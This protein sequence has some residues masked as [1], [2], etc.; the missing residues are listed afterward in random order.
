MVSDEELR[1]KAEKRAEEKIGFYTHLGIYLAVNLLLIVI[2]YTSSGPDTFP[3]FIYA[4]VG[5]G[6]GILAHFIGVHTS[7]SY[8]DKLAEKEYRKIKE[9]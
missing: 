2:W 6:V 1:K 3:W 7:G 9:K 4:T 8:K 5:W